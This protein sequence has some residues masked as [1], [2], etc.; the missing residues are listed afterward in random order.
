MRAKNSVDHVSAVLRTIVDNDVFDAEKVDAVREVLN[1]KLDHQM[2]N[3]NAS[4]SLRQKVSQPE[5]WLPAELAAAVLAPCGGLPGNTVKHTRVCLLASFF[6]AGGLLHA[7]ET[8]SRDIVALALLDDADSNI[9]NDGLIWVRLF[10]TTVKQVAKN[11]AEHRCEINNHDLTSPTDMSRDHPRWFESMYGGKEPGD[12]TINAIRLGAVRQLLG[13]R[14]TRHSFA[15]LQSMQRRG[16]M[17]GQRCHQIEQTGFVHPQFMPQLMDRERP[18]MLTDAQ[19]TFASPLIRSKSSLQLVPYQTPTKEGDRGTEAASSDTPQTPREDEAGILEPTPGTIAPSKATKGTPA[20]LQL[21]DDIKRW[22]SVVGGPSVDPKTAKKK[23]KMGT[24]TKEPK[25]TPEG[26]HTA[27]LKPKKK[28]T[29]KRKLATK[30]TDEAKFTKSTKTTKYTKTKA[31]TKTRKTKAKPTTKT[32]NKKNTPSLVFPGKGKRSPLVYGKSTVYFSPYRYRLMRR[33][34]DI[35][36]QAFSYKEANP[37]D[38]WRKVC[39]E[40]RR[41]NPGL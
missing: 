4:G 23:K 35:V 11:Y 34:G 20:Q 5:K 7:E 25:T 38:A 30:K 16:A 33:T 10:K 8:T 17:P 6:G 12:N 1:E 24:T 21:Q 27:K 15:D 37:R 22:Q 3:S 39:K 31:T 19:P 13:C 18:L 28:H 26:K 36:D 40:L 2:G 9:V 14:S 32:T 41:L 29:K